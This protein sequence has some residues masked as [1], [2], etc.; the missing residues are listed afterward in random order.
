[1]CHQDGDSRDSYDGESD[2]D[3][4]LAK[5]EVWK[6]ISPAGVQHL[7]DSIS[8]SDIVSSAYNDIVIPDSERYT[9]SF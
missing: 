6:R 3:S 5:A 8:E 2:P 4:G 7:D 1:M 9:S